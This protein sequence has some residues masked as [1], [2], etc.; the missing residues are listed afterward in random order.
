MPDRPDHILVVRGGALGDF[1]LTLPV[2]AAV[3]RQFPQARITVL[4]QPGIASLAVWSGLADDTKS[5]A[6]RQFAGCFE[7]AAPIPNETA[8]LF[9]RATHIVSYLHD[10][11]GTF[12]RQ[13]ARHSDA[14][15]LAGEFR[16]LDDAGVHATDVLLQALGEL[17]IQGADPEPR[18]TAPHPTS[19]RPPGR[20]LAIHPGSGSPR[21]NWPVSQWS[22]FLPRLAEQRPALR[23]LLIG[24]EAEQDL[25]PRIAK[26][27]PSDRLEVASGRAL[28][29]LAGRLLHADFFLGH[30]SGI[31][32][33]AAALGL[34][35]VV[36]WGE[37]VAAVWA[38]RSAR[39][40]RIEAGR[41]LRQLP[42][43]SVVDTLDRFFPVNEDAQ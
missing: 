2:F 43:Q 19:P 13:V 38:P 12:R 8:A 24:G 34:A 26:L 22:T 4:G 20:W 1:I 31:S 17:G 11:A 3:R 18:I 28:P 35:G 40:H 6:D 7:A 10:P 39:F 9:A 37:T 36:L 15:F 23:L 32:H 14:I 25:L 16:P 5:L 42:S 27:W 21:K 29:E 33:L 41:Q 30:D